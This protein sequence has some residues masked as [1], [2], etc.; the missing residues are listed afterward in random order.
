MV[1]QP[2]SSK[3]PSY[4]GYL[5]QNCVTLAELLSPAGYRCYLSG[6]WHVGEFRPV[7]PIDRGFHHSYGLISGA[8]NYW[9][10]H[11]GKR[12]GIERIFVED[13]SRIDPSQDPEFYA[14]TAFTQK[15]LGYLD[16]HFDSYA[17]QPFFLYLAYTAPHWP[18]HAPESRIQKH[19]ARYQGGWDSLREAR[20]DR[21]RQMKLWRGQE[22]L[23]AAD[24]RSR[25]WSSLNSSQQASC[26]RTVAKITSNIPPATSVT[27]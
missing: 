11:Q 10:I 5:N 6:K 26:L 24:P 17:D 14:T 19:L 2:D 1:N 25:P 13:S 21:I 4:Q 7:W 18:M 3:A 20:Y 27:T 23:T 9:N 8:M 22:S 12:M 15:A 16:E